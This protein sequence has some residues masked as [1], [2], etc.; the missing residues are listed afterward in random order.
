[1]TVEKQPALDRRA[2]VA[3]LVAGRSDEVVVAG[4]GS[5]AWDLAAAGDHP[6]NFYLW[7]AMGSAVMI[8]LGLALARP[9][10]RVLVLTGD[11]EMLMGMG[12]LASVSV[13]R[14]SNLAVLVLDNQVY[15]ETGGQVSHTGH[16][17]DLAGIAAG[18]GF[19]EALTI[20]GEGEVERAVQLLRAAPGPAFVCAKVAWRRVPLVLPPVEGGFLKNRLRAALGVAG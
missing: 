17:A 3:R 2:L 1:M 12:A 7:G 8:G 9:E 10:R 19:R 4:L 5:P 20:A 16:G 11:G 13:R 14:P 18:A 15:G 6:L